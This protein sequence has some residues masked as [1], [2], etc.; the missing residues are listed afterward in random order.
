VIGSSRVRTGSNPS[1]GVGSVVSQI[2]RLE[3]VPGNTGLALCYTHNV[4][5]I[6]SVDSNGLKFA[7]G[8]LKGLCHQFRRGKKWYNL[9]GLV[10]TSGANYL[11]KFV[12]SHLFSTGF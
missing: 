1:T 12:L 10:K 3:V 5:I 8:C 6:T 2:R 11:K 7:G 4:D 9:I